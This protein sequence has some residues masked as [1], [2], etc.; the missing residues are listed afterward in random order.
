[1]NYLVG[2]M[3][4]LITNDMLLCTAPSPTINHNHQNT[5]SGTNILRTIFLIV[6]TTLGAGLLNFPQAF[7][8]AGGLV[9]SISVQLISLIF[10]TAALIIL[11][12]CS[13]ITNT[14]SMQDVF[15]NFYG[16][17]SFLLCA[18]C[19]MIYSFGCCLTFLIVIGD[20]FDRVLATY[21]G[22]DYC[23]TWY[24]SRTFVT[25]V[26]SSIFILPLCFFK[27]LDILGY[28]SSIGCVTILYVALLVVYKYFTNIETPNNPMKIWPDNKFEALQIIPIICFA[29]QNHMTAIPMY[30]CMKERKI[31]KFILCAIASMIICFIVYTIV[32]IFGY[33]T[34]G[35]GKVPSDILQGYADK[36]IILTLG[37]IFI[38]IKNFTTYPIILY[39]GRDALLSLLG[40][41]INV[42]IKC[43]I[44]ITLIWYILSLIIAVFVPDISP[45]INLLGTLSAAFIFIFP[46][47]CLFQCTLLK[48]SELH[49]NKDRLLI[50]FAIFI[51]ALGA[52]T[53]GV[54]FV[55]AIKDLNITPKE[56][57]VI[58]GFRQLRES[59]C[60]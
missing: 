16:Q 54:V 4:Q 49:L 48:D 14:S 52:F 43:R 20:Q 31:N 1:M 21:Y 11:A 26:T 59:L 15:A 10:I 40:L 50:F 34:F 55:E 30:A 36:S 8:K 37:I 9:T 6:N 24:L 22:L 12:N 2:D 39:C 28:V 17:R 5:R 19:I 57:P 41:D 13:D 7:D 29:Y 44:F 45:V 51:T 35:A 56:T 47:I 60:T 3:E 58:T 25:V 33:A 23:H 53:S 32:G 46:G 18:F 42:T 27:K 38:A